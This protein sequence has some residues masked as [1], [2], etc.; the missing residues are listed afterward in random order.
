VLKEN[1]MAPPIRILLQTTIAPIANDWH[2]GRFSIL[3]D[4]LA[5]L[6]D[7]DGALLCAV[8]ARDRTPPGAPDPVLSTIDRS[9]LDELWLFAVD[10][11]DGLDPADWF[12]NRVDEETIIQLERAFWPVTGGAV[13]P[14]E[15][16]SPN[17][18]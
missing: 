10:T 7:A 13:Q 1:I 8:T 6:T 4:Y 12:D 15:P 17:F 9:D 18:K 11:G 2:I 14:K 5:G 3:R 16:G